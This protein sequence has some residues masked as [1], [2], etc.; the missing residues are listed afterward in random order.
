MPMSIAQLVLNSGGKEVCYLLPPK[1]QGNTQRRLVN[2]TVKVRRSPS[3]YPCGRRQ[4]MDVGRA[5]GEE[6]SP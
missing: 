3:P 2:A 6:G 5:E 1:P 4:E